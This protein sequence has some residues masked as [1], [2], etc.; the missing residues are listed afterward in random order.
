MFKNLEEMQ[1]C[2]KNRENYTEM[3][4]HTTHTLLAKLWGNSY[5]PTLWI[6][7]QNGITYIEGKS[8]YIYKTIEA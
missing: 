2:S 4:F 3:P 6:E 5:C 1:R 8:G 7:M